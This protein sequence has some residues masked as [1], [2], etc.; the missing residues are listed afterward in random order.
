MKPRPN[1]I[2]SQLEARLASRDLDLAIGVLYQ[3][4]ILT[5]EHR[6]GR[7]GIQLKAQLPKGFRFD[8]LATEIRAWEKDFVG[9]KV[10][11]ALKER[12]IRD[13]RWIEK[14]QR[15]LKPFPLLQKHP[16][17]LMVDPRG[18]LPSRKASDT[19]YIQSGL[20]FGTGTHTTTQLAAE[21]LS[22]ALEGLKCPSVLDMGCGTGILAMVSRRL[23][24]AKVL[25][26]DNDPEALVVA[27]ENLDIN[28]IRGVQLQENLKGVK[29]KFPVIVSNIV[30][31]VLLELR[32]LL[33]ARLAKGGSLILTGLLYRDRDEILR[34]YR[35][36][37]C[38]KAVNRKGWT[39]FLF[40]NRRAA[41]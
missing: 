20:A 8:K 19:L 7:D 35:G 14:Y 5:T 9:R 29:T 36:L 31:N 22:E 10:F 18:I 17:R 3:R 21:L 16:S 28:Q 32:P 26:V 41:P 4:G 30:L 34:A 23:G 12:K 38:R 33:V 13:Q 40:E 37:R 39:A 2:F 27:R 25:A 6:R 15:M 11:R 1:K 24:A